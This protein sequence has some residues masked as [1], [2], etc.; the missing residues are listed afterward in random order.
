MTVAVVTDSTAD[1]SAEFIAH[2]HISVVPLT[3]EWGARSYQD[4]V[5]LDP[6]DF[7]NQLPRLAELPKTAA[8]APGVFR[9]VYQERLKAG[10]DGVLSIHVAGRLSATVQSAQTAAPLVDGPV[11]V[12]DGGSASL[13]TGL[14]VWWA[15]IR[16][17]SGVNLTTLVK[18]VNDLKTG[19]FALI[20]PVTLEY[21]ARG[22][23]IGQAARWVGTLLD[24]KPILVLERGILRPERKVRGERQ[25]VPAMRASMAGRVPDG[26][27]VLAA[28]GHSGDGGAFRG[29]KDAAGS[30][31]DVVGWLDGVIGP[32]VSTHVG[33]GAYGLIILPLLASQATQFK[34]AMA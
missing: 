27:P 21:L 5:D 25:I 28:V 13:G 17:Q 6:V 10:A 14:L 22:G 2:Y 18:E 7:L 11:A 20:A 9:S 31:L 4:R 34:E 33:P 24:M 19:L 26:T 1:L 29:L 8:P 30:R 23:R 32:V 12:V 15:A 16:A 3:I